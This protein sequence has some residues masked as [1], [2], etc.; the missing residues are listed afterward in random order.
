ME[1]LENQEKYSGIQ[2]KKAAL[3]R[4]AAVFGI[5]FFT[6]LGCA[7]LVS[8][9]QEKEE[10]I[11]AAFTAESTV[12]RVESQLNKYLAESNLMKRMVE[13]GYEPDDGFLP[14]PI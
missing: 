4:L 14:C 12:S 13:S 9:N 7:G 11:Q 10:K 2:G 8:A 6:V 3:L 1:N 5:T